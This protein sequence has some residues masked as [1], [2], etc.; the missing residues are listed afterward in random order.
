MYT[1]IQVHSNLSM[2]E[3]SKNGLPQQTVL[4]IFYPSITSRSIITAKPRMMP[5]VAQ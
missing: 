1:I 5:M 3:Y 2:H 4:V